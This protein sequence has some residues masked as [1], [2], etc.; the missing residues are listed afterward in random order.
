MVTRLRVLIVEDSEI[1]TELLLGALERAGYDVSYER[2]QTAD[3]MEAALRRE[4]WDLIISDYSMPTFS[5]PA[6]LVVL[7]SAGLDVPFIIVSGMIG[8]ETAVAALKAGADDFMI[9][10][11]LARLGPAI[12]RELREAAGRRER[13]HLEEQLRQSQKL[14]AIGR[15][16]GGVAHDFNNVL[17]AILGF[18]E[19]LLAESSVDD[20][21]YADLFQ[22]KSAGQRGAGLVRQLL[23]FSRKQILQPQVLDVNV[24][25]ASMEKMLRQLIVEDIELRMSLMP[26]RALI[27]IDPTQLEQILINLAVNAADAMPRGG[28]ITIATA[29][30]RLDEGY[31][32]QRLPVTPGDYVKLAVSDN[33]VGMNEEISGHIFEPF[34]TTKAVG[35]GTGL[36][37]ATVYGIVK[38]SGGDILVSSEPG[39]GTM[40]TVYLPLTTATA[41]SPTD[42]PCD[43]GHAPRGSATV[44]LV[45]DDDAVRQFAGIALERAGYHV[46][47]AGNPGEAVRLVGDSA[48]TIDLLLSDVIMPDSEG[49]PLFDRL[50]PAHKDLR[51]LYM[52]GYADDAIMRHGVTVEGAPFLQKPFT[53][54]QLA[55]K[56]RDVLEEPALGV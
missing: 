5:A 21:G 43:S 25:V 34:F 22:I 10:G 13:A 38:Q 6:A 42:R 49:P 16:A 47:L 55:R 30:V 26:Q 12:E 28:K 51:V 37:L 56:V 8:E 23:A 33:G 11:R 19:L 53:P 52:S 3:T 9:K 15:L 27:R 44:L 18:A 29:A 14:E 39:C 40:F 32:Q 36:G 35:K 24:V 50:R 1:D 41:A 20:P 17:T 4:A 7:Q 31:R 2:V 48:R 54:D 45:E 46:L